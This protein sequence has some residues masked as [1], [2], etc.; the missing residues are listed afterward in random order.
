M[1]DFYDIYVRTPVNGTAARAISFS[2]AEEIDI[3]TDEIKHILKRLHRKR[4]L[5]NTAI[6]ITTKAKKKPALQDWQRPDN[7]QG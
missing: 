3:T 5:L 4:K 6:G 1:T 7:S 2:H